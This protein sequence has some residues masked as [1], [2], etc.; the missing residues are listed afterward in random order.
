MAGLVCYYNSAKFHYLYVS[1]D[2]DAR[3]TS[4]RDVVPAGSGAVRRLHAAD[5]DS[6]GEPVRTA[7]RGGLRAAA[8]RVSRRRSGQWHWLPQQFDASILSDEA[9]RA[10]HAELHRRL[11]RHGCQDLAGTAQPGGLRLLRVSRARLFAGIEIALLAGTA[12]SQ[13]YI[14]GDLDVDYIHDAVLIQIVRRIDYTQRFVDDS[15]RVG[16]TVH[17]IAVHIAGT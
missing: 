10:R 16:N 15:L 7:R 6:A 2:D 5:R 1:H 11:R 14:D 8:I 13:D 3:Q 17:A 4:A 9:T 12:R